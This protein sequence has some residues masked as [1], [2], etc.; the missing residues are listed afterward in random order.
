MSLIYT[1]SDD[2]AAT[3]GIAFNL[4]YNASAVSASLVENFVYFEFGADS[5]GAEEFADTSDIDGN[6]LTDVYPHLLLERFLRAAG[7]GRANCR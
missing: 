7:Q 6:S 4:H 2:N 1:T 5:L 3:D